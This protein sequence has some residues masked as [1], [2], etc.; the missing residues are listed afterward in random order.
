[1]KQ[2]IYYLI[3]LIGVITTK[4]IFCGINDD[5][6]LD[7][8]QKKIFSYQALE[9]TD[10]KPPL[11]FG[12]K[13]GLFE[14]RMRLNIV[15]DSYISKLRNSKEFSVYD[16]NMFVTGWILEALFD[17]IIYGKGVNLKENLIQYALDALDDFRDKNGAEKKS[18]KFTFWLQNYNSEF[19]T[20]YC[21][22][23]NFNGLV[24]YL[25]N[26]SLDALGTKFSEQ[27]P[28]LYKTLTFF[29]NSFDTNVFKIPSDFDDSFLN[30]AIGSSLLKIENLYPK[31]YHSWSI[32]N[33]NSNLLINYTLKY[34]YKPF[35][36]DLN[37]NLINPTTYYFPRPFIM[38]AYAK[39]QSLTLIT[40]WMQNIDEQRL[41][42]EFATKRFNT[43]NVDVTVCANS[44][45]GITAAVIYNPN[46]F[47][48]A[49]L[50]STQFQ[51]IYLNT[52]E[53][54]NWAIKTKF[55]SRP[56]LAL[57]YYPS[58]YTFFWFVSRSLFL[59]ENDLNIVKDNK[60]KEILLIVRMKLR[61][62]F[63]NEV[64]DFFLENVKYENTLAYYEEFLGLS[65]RPPT[66]EDRLCSTAQAINILIATWTYQSESG[67]LKWKSNTDEKVKNLI[68]ACVDWLKI[69]IFYPKLKLSNAFFSGESRNLEA[70]PYWYPANFIQ[71]LNGT[72]LSEAQ[73]KNFKTLVY[74]VSGVIEEDEYEKKLQQ[75]KFGRNT[76]LN[77]NGYNSDEN[78]FT[79]WASEP[80]TYT[81][82]LL[83]LSQFNNLDLVSVQPKFEF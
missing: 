29:K 51:E 15:G 42:N 54:I 17:A 69:N 50:N 73:V 72:L 34:A 43:N 58:V 4:Q 70:L 24:K 80:I 27:Q 46:G 40:T 65:D 25:E 44:V 60:V 62:T 37:S 78:C 59:L 23:E 66:G 12:K 5:Y 63:E 61:K 55:S 22:N 48:D 79:F 75:K 9:T 33:V 11:E 82:A 3:V 49:F 41:Q 71:D 26:A 81:F 38:E 32:N 57:V 2:E 7:N 14:T 16:N 68:K 10:F 74:G 39:N 36:S 35:D 21:Q 6:L 30:L 45:Y 20:W 77:F 19:D 13:F 76:P 31:L 1:M 18:P 52:T 28:K 56:D 47:R 83:A 53:F 8:L 67:K 64:T